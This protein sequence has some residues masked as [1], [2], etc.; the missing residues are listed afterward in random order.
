VLS[1]TEIVDAAAQLAGAEPRRYEVLVPLVRIP[2]RA[3][4]AEPL[5]SW[6]TQAEVIAWLKR[7]GQDVSG[8]RAGGGFMFEFSAR[9][10]HS[11]VSQARPLVERLVARSSF[12]RSRRGAIEP[13]H[14]VWVSGLIGPVP[15]ATPARGADIL[16]LVHDGHLYRVDGPSQ[17][18]DDALELAA[19]LNQGALAPALASGWAAVESLLSNPDD[20]REDGGKVAAADRLAAIVTCSWPRAELTSL[21][22]HHKPAAGDELSL[23]IAGCA[24]NRER[25]RILAAALQ[26]EARLS[27]SS[28]RYGDSEEAAAERMRELLVDPSRTLRDVQDAFVVAIRRFYRAR[29]IVLHGASVRGVS[30]EAALRTGAPLVGAG[31]DRITHAA[32]AEGLDPLDLAARA[33]ASLDLV[34]GETGLHV[35]DLLTKPGEAAA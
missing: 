16:S 35:V 2:Q 5:S 4:L 12:L 3:R 23:R 31:L 20:P 15:L 9:D 32:L 25:S 28:R 34:G 27:F 14:C 11:A 30:L 29:N 19:P 17:Q 7:H 24:T 22:H 18:I 10:P 33:E 6:R 1:A 26:G 8:V 21:A 13:L